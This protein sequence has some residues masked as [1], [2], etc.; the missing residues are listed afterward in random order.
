MSVCHGYKQEFKKENAGTLSRKGQADAGENKVSDAEK[1]VG[2]ICRWG[3]PEL[4]A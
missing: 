1:E 4:N 3:K 2:S